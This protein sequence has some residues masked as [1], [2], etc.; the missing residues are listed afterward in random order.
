MFRNF[1]IKM[2]Q[3]FCNS[4]VG[5]W[6]LNQFCYTSFG[7]PRVEFFIKF[8][9]IKFPIELTRI[10]LSN[11][12]T[13]LEGA[14]C[15]WEIFYMIN[16]EFITIIYLIIL[17]FRILFFRVWPQLRGVF[18]NFHHCSSSRSFKLADFLVLIHFMDVRITLI[19]ESQ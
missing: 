10:K 17:C 8:M 16:D 5:L 1:L 9:G 2:S 11:Q 13:G 3:C 7:M 12:L 19:T 6:F 15:P 4:D 14:L 18:R